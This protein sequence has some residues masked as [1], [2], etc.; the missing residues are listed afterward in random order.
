MMSNKE[1]TDKM[2]CRSHKRR[3]FT[4]AELLLALAITGILLAGVAVAFDA[5]S[6]SHTQNEQM[7]KSISKARQAMQ[8]M[9]AQLRTANYVDPNGTSTS[10]TLTTGD[11]ESLTYNYVADAQKLYL[12]TNDDS[13]DPDYV[14]CNNVSAASFEY[15][16]FDDAGVTKVKY[17]Q[18]SLT[19]TEGDTSETVNGAAAIR[20]NLE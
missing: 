1:R 20:R 9:S 19:I 6:R 4:I 8:R 16:T 15:G 3:A 18:I 11:G 7:F 13:S 12:I 17:V 5:L 10:C 2:S 14:L